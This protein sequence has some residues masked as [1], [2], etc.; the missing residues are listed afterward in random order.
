MDRTSGAWSLLDKTADVLWT[1][2]TSQPRF[3]RITLR[4]GTRQ[5]VCRI[6]R[7]DDVASTPHSL[8][9]VVHPL[10]DGSR[11]ASRCS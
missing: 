5:E 8:R 4:N 10:V 2:S 11:P 7:F 3:G 9:L 1:S 6:D